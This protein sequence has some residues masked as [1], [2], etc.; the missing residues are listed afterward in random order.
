GFRPSPA[1]T[2]RP[3]AGRIE[4]AQHRQGIAM[5]GFNHAALHAQIEN[6][7]A[8]VSRNEAV[9]ALVTRALKAGGA[10]LTAHGALAAST[11]VYTGR[12]PRDKFIASDSLTR[13]RVWWENN[14]PLSEAHFAALLD[15]FLGAMMGRD[16]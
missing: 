12:S 11:G 13:D 7:A 15:D 2:N 4:P 9:P 3:V 1:P 5:T 6:L 8:S 10:D 16:L 14:A